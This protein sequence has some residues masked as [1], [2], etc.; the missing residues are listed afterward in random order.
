[1]C[2]HPQDLV[3][4]P[5]ETFYHPCDRCRM[6]VNPTSTGHQG[7]KTCKDMTAAKLQREAISNSAAAL[8]E[9]IYAYGEELESRYLSTWNETFVLTTM[10]PRQ[11]V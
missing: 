1:M 5:G 6:Q 3:D 2:L 10:T 11:S 9:N 7:M 8:D 4:V